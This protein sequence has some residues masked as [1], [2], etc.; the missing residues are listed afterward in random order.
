MRL[1]A[2]L[3]RAGVASRR[4]S[5]ELIKAGRVTVN[6]E[7]GQLNTFVQSRDRVELDGVAVELQPLA[8]VLLH[9]PAGAVTTASDPQGRRTVVELVDHPARVVP[10][11]RLDV[12]TTGALLL[13]NDGELAHRL[14]HPRYEVEK[15]YEAEVEGDPT[16]DA[17]DPVREGIQLD[18]GPTSPA[19]A[20][21]LGAEMILGR[22]VVGLEQ[23]GPV[24]AVRFD[25]GTEI[26]AKAV[27]VATGVSY[28]RL[29]APGLAE[30]TGRGVFY[31]AS[32]NDSASTTGDDVFV[33]GAA[34]SAGQAALHL[35]R[36]AKRV[37][38]V[39]RGD[40]LE[41]SMSKYLVQRINVAE[42]I[43]VLLET[44]IVRGRGVDHL[45]SLTIIDRSTGI[46]TEMDA[47][48]LFAFIGAQPRTEWLGTSIERDE[49]GFI[50]TGT[51]VSTGP[52][53][54]WPL[55]RAPMLLETSR[56]GVF[57][58]GDARLAS[59]KRVASAVGEGSIAVSLVHL[60]LETL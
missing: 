53:K 41:K 17:L 48:W 57:A 27:L 29:E 11:G 13:T 10:V 59:M 43:E 24:H 47:S 35:A 55:D 1:N 36:Y 22:G 58:A 15:V 44:E 34:N 23:R 9:K 50:L 40:A 14:A 19:Q 49:R 25:D 28:R 51:E 37:V 16:E 21:R 8:Y 39:V 33:V 32:A 4:R 46:E 3:A 42:N 30:L 60:Y 20:R 56:P 2:Y 31:G 7:P 54:R 52:A 6:G 45:E 38:L 5:D 12:D 26:D 18:D